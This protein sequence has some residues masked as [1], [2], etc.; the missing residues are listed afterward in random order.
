MSGENVWRG[1]PHSSG[2]TAER[3]GGGVL[4]ELPLNSLAEGIP[5]SPGDSAGKDTSPS[6]SATKKKEAPLAHHAANSDGKAGQCS[7]EGVPT[8]VWVCLGASPPLTAAIST[9]SSDGH[10]DLDHLEITANWWCD[11]EKLQ[12]PGEAALEPP[13]SPFSRL[14]AGPARLRD[15]PGWT[16]HSV[17]T[18]EAFED[19]GEGAGPGSPGAHFSIERGTVSSPASSPSGSCHLSP[20]EGTL[21]T[22]I[23]ASAAGDVYTANEN[24]AFLAF[25]SADRVRGAV[26]VPRHIFPRS[27]S[28]SV[29]T[30]DGAEAEP[31]VG[32]GRQPGVPA[33]SSCLSPL[34]SDSASDAKLTE[35]LAGANAW[36]RG[37]RCLWASPAPSSGGSSLQCDLAQQGKNDFVGFRVPVDPGA[38]PR[39]AVM[40][41]KGGRQPS[42][43]TEVSAEAS[44]TRAVRASASGTAPKDPAS[45]EARQAWR[46]LDWASGKVPTSPFTTA[47]A[48]ARPSAAA[49]VST[50]TASCQASVERLQGEKAWRGGRD[51]AA[52]HR[53]SSRWRRTVAVYKAAD[54][55]R[56]L[57]RLSLAKWRAMAVECRAWRNSRMESTLRTMLKVRNSVLLTGYLLCSSWLR[58]HAAVRR[59]RAA[60]SLATRN[61]RTLSHGCLGWGVVGGEKGFQQ[62]VLLK[63]RKAAAEEASMLLSHWQ[64]RLKLRTLRLWRQLAS[65]SSVLLPGAGRATRK[66]CLRAVLR[67]W[68]HQC[69]TQALLRRA[70]VKS[71]RVSSRGAKLRATWRRWHGITAAQ[72]CF[73]ARALRFFYCQC[74]R[75]MMAAWSLWAASCFR[76]EGDLLNTLDAGFQQ[77]MQA[78]ALLNVP[79]PGPSRG[80]PQDGRAP[81]HGSALPPPAAEVP[82]GESPAGDADSSCGSL[83]EYI[84]LCEVSAATSVSELLSGLSDDSS[85][86]GGSGDA[87]ESRLGSSSET[88]SAKASWP[89]GDRV[90]NR[91]TAPVAAWAY[92]AVRPRLPLRS[93]ISPASSTSTSSRHKP[94]S[95]GSGW[96]PSGKASGGSASHGA[97]VAV[98]QRPK[99][100]LPPSGSKPPAAA[101]VSPSGSCSSN[102]PQPRAGLRPE[103]CGSPLLRQALSRLECEANE[104]ISQQ[105]HRIVRLRDTVKALAKGHSRDLQRR[106]VAVAFSRWQRHAAL[107]IVSV[108]PYVREDG[109]DVSALSRAY[110]RLESGVTSTAS[111]SSSPSEDVSVEVSSSQA[112]ECKPL[113]PRAGG[114]KG[115]SR[116][117]SRAST[118]SCSVDKVTDAPETAGAASS[119]RIPRPPALC[120]ALPR[121]REGNV[122]RR[123]VAA[124]AMRASSR[125]W[126]SRQDPATLSSVNKGRDSSDN[127]GAGNS[128]RLPNLQVLCPA[129]QGHPAGRPAS[130]RPLARGGRGK[131]HSASA[132]TTAAPPPP[133]ASVAAAGQRA[134]ASSTWTINMERDSQQIW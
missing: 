95:V 104:V 2:G 49:S 46:Y 114:S 62:L 91:G 57:L 5:H 69:A 101:A 29:G 131:L 82:P 37:V 67:A 97:R 127:A 90:Q 86:E 64:L 109:M 117:A 30:D 48:A 31:P 22:P 125:P 83:C 34:P 89:S 20:A 11:V 60:A 16:V 12:V 79:S 52:E 77:L 99:Q 126:A 81:P 78:K 68:A 94:P 118:A 43:P 111:A 113:L 15:T 116:C 119:S 13:D 124:G 71:V 128:S 3:S 76:R 132:M 27:P 39:A 88:A 26:E 17:R 93:K 66:Q 38:L 54:R 21:P 40:P 120:Q 103:S 36:Q 115:Q 122:Q 28:R 32:R 7:L 121:H 92:P 70:I 63:W 84:R 133:E 44:G 61:G 87:A 1:S 47:T 100:P 14:A 58:W 102:Q 129:P 18:N 74:Q 106:K 130:S 9:P 85:S 56:S 45:R 112:S 134:E 75:R 73:Q 123:Q 10:R 41:D 98:H 59:S 33:A 4:Q 42:G 96:R 110:H 19:Q 25:D 35:V 65:W 50:Q 80:E 107:G 24:V 72:R 105:N 6:G 23:N 55:W 53:S 108:I 51:G 8:D